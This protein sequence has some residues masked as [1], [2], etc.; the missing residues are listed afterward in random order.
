MTAPAGGFAPR[1][2]DRMVPAVDTT[3]G[4]AVD[5][6]DHLP[7][8]GQFL[9]EI[10]R[11]G[12][13]G[14]LARYGAPV[15]L[16]AAGAVPR[17]RAAF[18]TDRSEAHPVDGTLAKTAVAW[19]AKR[20]NGELPGCVWLGR[21]PRYDVCLPFSGVSKLHAGLLPRSDGTWAVT[22]AG[23]LNGTSV[24]DV[25]VAPGRSR[26][27]ADGDRLRFAGLEALFLTAPGFLDEVDRIRRAVDA[28]RTSL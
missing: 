8:I 20:G 19:V 22:D 12:R 24:N 18:A 11:L 27:L 1:R 14:F 17:A 3:P 15:L 6:L 23:S 21:D 10:D 13:A 9:P 26:D 4:P 16:F 25:A 28:L 5:N 7:R 2:P